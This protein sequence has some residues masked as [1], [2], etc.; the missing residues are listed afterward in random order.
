MNTNSK[1]ILNLDLK[2]EQKNLD[3]SD[4]QKQKYKI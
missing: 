1:N 3:F 4:F 2:K